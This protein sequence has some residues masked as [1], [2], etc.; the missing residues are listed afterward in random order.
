VYVTHVFIEAVPIS[1]VVALEHVVD[2][3]AAS[4]VQL[5][6]N[7]AAFAPVK[8][9]SV[10]YTQ[11]GHVVTSFIAVV[12]VHTGQVIVWEPVPM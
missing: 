3:L 10:L 4:I 11:L 7:M 12:I 6:L 8:A 1:V 9:A 2:L 5:L